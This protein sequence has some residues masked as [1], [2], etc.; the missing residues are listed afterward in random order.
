MD[1]FSLEDEDCSQMFITQSS[2]NDEQTRGNF[3]VL[4]DEFDFSSPCVSLLSGTNANHA[5][6]SDISEDEFEQIPCSQKHQKAP[7]DHERY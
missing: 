6:Y 4:G 5:Q 1:V 3:S 7:D 2:S